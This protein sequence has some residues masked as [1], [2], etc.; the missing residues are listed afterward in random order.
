MGVQRKC[1]LKKRKEFIINKKIAFEKYDWG[2]IYT[3]ELMMLLSQLYIGKEILPGYLVSYILMEEA[4]EHF[5][6]IVTFYNDPRGRYVNFQCENLPPAV[7]EYDDLPVCLAETLKLKGECSGKGTYISLLDIHIDDKLHKIA[8]KVSGY[9]EKEDLVD[10]FKVAKLFSAPRNWT[11][12]HVSDIRD[13]EEKP[14]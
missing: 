4:Y 14:N 3:Q 8:Q 9:F 13:E 2:S 1:S 11:S 6:D 7:G 12:F 10:W 5:E